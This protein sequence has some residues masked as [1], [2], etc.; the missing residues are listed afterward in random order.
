MNNVFCKPT[1]HAVWGRRRDRVNLSPKIES[2]KP[3]VIY[4][5]QKGKLL[6]LKDFS[7]AN[8]RTCV[9]DVMYVYQKFESTYITRFL[10]IIVLAAYH[11]IY[12]L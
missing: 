12:F 10:F 3:Y 1:K 8:R 2:S 7:L 9:S 4:V 6:H 5:P 11:N